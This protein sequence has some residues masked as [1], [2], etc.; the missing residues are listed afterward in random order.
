MKCGLNQK[1]N[2]LSLQTVAENRKHQPS[3]ISPQN[4]STLQRKQQ[5]SSNHPLEQHVQT[6][7]TSHSTQH[8]RT[9]TP[10]TTT[11][12]LLLLLISLR[13]I[14]LLLVIHRLLASLW[15]TISLLWRVALLRRVALLLLGRHESAIWVGGGRGIALLGWIVTVLGC[16]RC[17][18]AV[19]VCC[20][21]AGVVGGSGVGGWWA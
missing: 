21:A 15:P 2:P 5:S 9:N 3:L 8:T 16:G 10:S 18:V 13:R 1:N 11:T 4:A 20:F 6:T 12:T 19:V 7:T 14:A 17:G